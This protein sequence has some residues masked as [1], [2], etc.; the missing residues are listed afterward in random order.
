MK[1]APVAIITLNRYEHLKCCIESLNANSFAENTDLYISVDYPPS[2]KYVEGYKKV[3]EYLSSVTGN[4]KSINL[5][6]QTA[7]LGAFNN[8]DFLKNEIYKKHDSLILLEDD[9][10]VA[11]NFLDFCNKG[12]VKF[13]DDPEVMYIN[14]TNYVWSGNGF[15]PRNDRP[16]KNGLVFKRQVLWHGYATWKKTDELIRKVS[17]TEY[18]KYGKNIK[19][20]FILYK[21]SRFFFYAYI[22]DVLLSNKKKLPWV[23]GKIYPIDSVINTYLLTH[24]KYVICPDVN[25]IR[26]RGMDGSGLNFKEKLDEHEHLLSLEISQEREFK[27]TEGETE[28][29]YVEIEKHDRYGLPKWY[30]RI[31]FLLGLLLYWMNIIVIE[32]NDSL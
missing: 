23:N 13:K 4:F 9:N 22:R 3:K 15:I 6:Y 21:K 32:E 2:E 14:G 17:C 5:F 1:C 24:D 7:N 11:L 19:T 27:M 29:S 16:Y 18:I 8:I 30:K 25:L 12:L 20:M 28:Y 26:D 10:E 31:V